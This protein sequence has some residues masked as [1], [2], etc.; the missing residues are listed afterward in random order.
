MRIGVVVMAMIMAGPMV[1]V[2]VVVLVPVLMIMIMIMIMMVIVVMGVI[3]VMMVVPVIMPRGT[4]ADALHMMVVA[5]LRQ[6][7][8][9]CTTRTFPRTI[10]VVFAS[11]YETEFAQAKMCSETP[12]P[13]EALTALAET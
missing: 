1:M 3:M 7:T 6:A 11:F 12:V 9:F 2:P 10:K 8:R 4:G 13:E 5:L